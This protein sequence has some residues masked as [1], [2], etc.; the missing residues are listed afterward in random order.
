MK[1]SN[2]F[3]PKLKSTFKKQFFAF[4]LISPSPFPPSFNN[5][6]NSSNSGTNPDAVSEMFIYFSIFNRSFPSASP[7]PNPASSNTFCDCV[8]FASNFTSLRRVIKSPKALSPSA[9]YLIFSSEMMFVYIYFILLRLWLSISRLNLTQRSSTFFSLPYLRMFLRKADSISKEKT[10]W[11]SGLRM[12]VISERKVAN[13]EK[14]VS[15]IQKI[16]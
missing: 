8:K 9:Q 13:S 15:L 11:A 14:N 1:S 7:S 16:K 4:T 6:F 10:R 12:A 5:Y 3:K 2:P